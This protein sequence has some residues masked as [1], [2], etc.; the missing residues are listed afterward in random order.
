MRARTDQATRAEAL[1]ILA[2]MR[3][4]EH[5]PPAMRPEPRHAAA[6]TDLA[7]ESAEPARCDCGGGYDFYSP[8]VS[9]F[10]DP[11]PFLVC[12]ACGAVEDVRD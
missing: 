6:L 8:P 7:C 1:L 11:G 9:G 10:E 5:E 4:G 12:R 2:A 3:P